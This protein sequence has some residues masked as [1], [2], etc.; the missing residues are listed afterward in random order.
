MTVLMNVKDLI[1][2]CIHNRKNAQ[3]MLYDSYSSRLYGVCLRYSG[4]RDEAQDILQESL[5]KIFKN[6]HTFKYVDE[7]LFY[8]WMYKITV[9]TALNHY[10]EWIKRN[11]DKEAVVELSNNNEIDE[12]SIFDTI[13]EHINQ[14]TLLKLIQELPIGYRTIFN[15]YVFENRTHKEIAEEFNISINTSKSQLFKARK[16][17]ITKINDI[18]ESNQVKKVV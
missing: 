9:N 18:L 17:L 12:Y 13:L 5:L 4:D 15:L 10:R 6:I 1:E 2:G 11:Q 16:I 14:Q 3:N 8:G 7:F